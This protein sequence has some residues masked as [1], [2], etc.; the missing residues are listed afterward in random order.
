MHSVI[1]FYQMEESQMRTLAE[2]VNE[3]IPG[4]FENVIPATRVE[5]LFSFS[6]S[7]KDDWRDHH[8]EILE[9]LKKISPVISPGNIYD[10]EL[11]IDLA[12]HIAA[13]DCDRFITELPLSPELI[14]V[15]FENRIWFTTT[16]YNTAVFQLDD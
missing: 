6:L 2:K 4:L 10:G 11:E 9:I 7:E 16:I 5:N 1:R 8:D 3:V 15:L 13:G 12:V 14:Q